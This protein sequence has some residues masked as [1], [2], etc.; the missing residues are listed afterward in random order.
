MQTIRT[1]CLTIVLASITLTASGPIYGAPPPPITITLDMAKVPPEIDID[2]K[3]RGLG[4]NPKFATNELQWKVKKLDPGWKV[5]I[6]NA[7]HHLACFTKGIPTGAENTGNTPKTNIPLASGE[8]DVSCTND[9]YG[10]YWPYVVELYKYE[11][12]NWVQKA[13]TDPGGIIHP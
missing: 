1:T 3:Y 11:N 12:G 4:K 7:P 8:P 9:K 6:D 13:S 5:V 2:I 10:V